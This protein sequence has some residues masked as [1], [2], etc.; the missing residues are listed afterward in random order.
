MPR[1]KFKKK[2]IAVA[3]F[4]LIMAISMLPKHWM[5]LNE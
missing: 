1:P 2:K 5:L 4:T 3:I